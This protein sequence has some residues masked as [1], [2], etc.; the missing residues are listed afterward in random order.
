MTRNVQHTVTS[1][2]DALQKLEDMY[3]AQH[4]CKLIER[5]NF[6]DFQETLVKKKMESIPDGPMG[7]CRS[8][9]LMWLEVGCW[10]H[11]GAAS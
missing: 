3:E 9:I 1:C 11:I 2:D 10:G 5:L 4:R 6:S 7:R 8:F